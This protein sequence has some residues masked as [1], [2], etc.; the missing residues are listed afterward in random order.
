MHEHCIDIAVCWNVWYVQEEGVDI[1]LKDGDSATP[2]H[3]AASR[4]HADSV[5][6]A[7][8]E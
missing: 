6:N 1:N 2:L 3:F 7:K 8:T 4:G 5:S